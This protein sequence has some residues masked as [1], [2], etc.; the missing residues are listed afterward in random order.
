MDIH[1]PTDHSADDEDTEQ[2]NN[3]CKRQKNVYV[4]VDTNRKGLT[5]QRQAQVLKNQQENE[6]LKAQ[7]LE[8]R[9][10]IDKESRTQTKRPIAQP[11]DNGDNINDTNS[12][13]PQR[14]K[15][16]A[17]HPDQIRSLKKNRKTPRASGNATVP[18]DPPPD[19]N[20]PD[21]DPLIGDLIDTEEDSDYALGPD[22]LGFYTFFL[23]GEGNLPDLLGIE[24]DQLLAI[25]NDL[26]KRMKA[27]DEGREGA[28]SKML[29]EL[30]RKHEFA[31]TQYLK[32]FAQVSELSEPTAKDT[33]T[34]VKP[35]DKML[36]LPP[37]FNGKKPEKAKTHNERFNQYIKFQ[38]KEGNIKDP[39]KEATELFEH[40]LDKKALIWFQQHKAD[41]K[42]LTTMKNMILARYDQWGKT[43]RDQLQSWNNLSFDP[44]K[45]DIDE[46]IDLV[47]T[48]GNMLQQDEQAKMDKFIKTMSTIIQTH[49]LI[50]APNWEEVTKKAKNLEHII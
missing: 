8:D 14:S 50:I 18:N 15:G 4:P 42:D 45:M 48:L 26:H 10:N 5:K 39:I 3:T 38:T 19:P 35:A 12:P 33:P 32:Y 40:T 2:D 47:L 24:D 7:A 41:F 17:S 49:Y 9:D 21:K 23:K 13:R 22:E 43:K 27:R 29:C 11:E 36:M 25:Q 6:R 37:L 28:I 30:E 1:T 34:R 16:K 44:Q 46:Q 20:T 31:N